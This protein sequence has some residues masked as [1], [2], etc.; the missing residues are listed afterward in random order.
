[1][2]PIFLGPGLNSTN[3]IRAHRMDFSPPSNHIWRIK[4]FEEN[5][6]KLP[7]WVSLCSKF[8]IKIETNAFPE[9]F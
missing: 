4:P 5:W 3:F 8:F 6:V 7:F 9:T 2:G 1:M